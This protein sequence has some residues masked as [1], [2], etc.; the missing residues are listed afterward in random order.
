MDRP[1]D[2]NHIYSPKLFTGIFRA[3]RS[4]VTRRRIPTRHQVE[5]DKK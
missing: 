2:M 1:Y 4:T 5:F 3:K